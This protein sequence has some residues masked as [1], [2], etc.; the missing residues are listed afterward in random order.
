LVFSTDTLDELYEVLTL[1]QIQSRHGWSDQELADHFTFLLANSLFYRVSH[2]FPPSLTRDVTDVK[3]LALAYVA[4]ASYLV[5]NDRR[6]LIPLR[7][8]GSTNIVTPAQ[9]VRELS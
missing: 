8:F 9:F 4:R 5:T 3:F 7:R 6:H 1:P 2:A